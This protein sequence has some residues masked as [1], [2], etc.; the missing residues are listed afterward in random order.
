[1]PIG[2]GVGEGGVFTSLRDADKVVKVNPKTGKLVG[3]AKVGDM[4]NGLAASWAASG[5]RTRAT[6]P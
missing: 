2:I 3:Q 1:M 4:P 5:S 6:G